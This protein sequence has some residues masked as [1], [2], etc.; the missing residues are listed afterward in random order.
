M[1]AFDEKDLID[2]I[3]NGNIESFDLLYDM[4]S[5]KIYNLAYQILGN[6]QEA[7][8]VTQDTFVQI[9][10]NIK[11]FKRNSKI[12]TWIYTIAKNLCYRSLKNKKNSF[13]SL[14]SLIYSVQSYEP[15]DEISEA[16]KTHLI[17]QVKEGCLI[18]L[19]RCLSYYQRISFILF[20]FVRR[21][22]REISQILD[23]S[24]GATKVLIHRARRN[25]KA[26]L[27]KNCSLYDQHNPCHC[28]NLI[29]F[30]L[31]QGWIKKPTKGELKEFDPI[32]TKT[33]ESEI[34]NFKKIAELY[35]SLSQNNPP[36]SLNQHIR[37]VIERE[38]WSIFHNQKV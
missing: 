20:T 37:Q 30:S 38:N 19:L 27:C 15:T 18:G 11:N 8:D 26:F 10:R 5:A 21:P 31:N 22:V 25:L 3:K 2:D 36:E 4:Y 33:I 9:F 28:E 24:E 17:Y 14:E 29:D 13:A 16:E 12:Y 34:K 32:D 23:K 35:N 1:D 7:E 6:K